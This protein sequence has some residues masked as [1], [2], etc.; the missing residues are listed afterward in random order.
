[1]I[2]IWA[3]IALSGFMG[4]VWVALRGAT[5]PRGCPEAGTML[6]FGVTVMLA[7]GLALGG[8]AEKLLP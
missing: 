8:V 6:G 5:L 1:M 4:G 3:W 7:C 2:Y